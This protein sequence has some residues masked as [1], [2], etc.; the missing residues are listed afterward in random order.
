ME[1]M[2]CVVCGSA[3]EAET[4]MEIPVCQECEKERKD[5]FRIFLEH[6]RILRRFL[7]KKAA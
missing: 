3:F 1:K 4:R 7:Y 5:P 6:R 2:A